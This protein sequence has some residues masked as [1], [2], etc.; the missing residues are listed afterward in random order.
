[1][2]SHTTP[3]KKPR[4]LLYDVETSPILAWIWKPGP[5]LH[6]SHEQ[7]KKGQKSDIICICYKW[8]GARSVHA[9]HWNM[10][11]QD[12]TAMIDAF[13]K[14][15][16][17]ADLVIGHNGD[18]FD[19]KHINT[20]RLL[21][22]KDPISW[23]T[24]EDTLKQFRKYFA[25]PSFKLDYLSKTLNG[26]GKDR[27]VFQDWIDIVENRS[28]SALAK[29]LRYCK[30]DVLH[31]EGIFKKAFKFFVPKI[32]ASLL[33]QGNREGC[34]RCGH[35]RV[36]SAGYVVRTTGRYKRWHCQGCGHKFKV[37]RKEPEGK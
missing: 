7:I 27:M 21:H 19:M 22:G 35:T 29:M 11:T 37:S 12:S 3:R 17:Q 25:F 23:P 32:N 2:S 1:M 10:T 14:I 9:L 15:V 20:Q 6:I 36:V 5:K 26:G 30:K 13:S 8:L 28:A 16:E 34:P 18:N 33:A 31:L 24:S 4:I